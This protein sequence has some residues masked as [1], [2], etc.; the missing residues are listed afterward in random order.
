MAQPFCIQPRSSGPLFGR[1]GSL[2]TSLCSS[3]DDAVA[4]VEGILKAI[5]SAGTHPTWPESDTYLSKSVSQRSAIE[6]SSAA[7]ASEASEAVAARLLEAEKSTDIA[8]AF[9]NVYRRIN[10][11]KG[12]YATPAARKHVRNF[13][14][15]SGRTGAEWLVKR[16][17][18]ETHLELLEGVADILAEIGTLGVPSILHALDKKPRRDRT[19][20]LLKALGWIGSNR[21]FDADF[22]PRLEQL[23]SSYL[24]DEDPDI[25]EAACSA[26]EILPAESAIRLLREQLERE[27]DGDVA[28]IIRESIEERN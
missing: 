17:E 1:I 24:R 3:Y 8:T 5:R 22:H 4:H 10:W 19:E 13:W 20:F 2:P 12:Q 18:R 23:I 11:Y 9:E 25:R 7:A 21:S 28:D 26:T 16:L 6:P 15:H 14:V 27:R